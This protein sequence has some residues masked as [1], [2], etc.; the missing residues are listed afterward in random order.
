MISY[1][2]ERTIFWRIL[3]LEVET[4]TL[5]RNVGHQLSVHM[6]V[7]PHPRRTETSNFVLV[8]T[9]KL[10][11]LRVGYMLQCNRSI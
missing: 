9:K 4:T 8:K 3:T 6:D 10:F 2:Y 11:Y 7:M 1:K 5:C